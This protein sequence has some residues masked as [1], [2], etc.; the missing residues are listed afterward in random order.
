MQRRMSFRIDMNTCARIIGG[1]FAV[2]TVLFLIHFALGTS[3]VSAQVSDPSAIT[4]SNLTTTSDADGKAETISGTASNYGTT[5]ALTIAAAT[6][7]GSFPQTLSAPIGTGGK[8]TVT[9]SSLFPGER[10]LYSIFDPLGK[11]VSE[12]NFFITADPNSG[13][14][15]PPTTATATATPSDTSVLISGSADPKGATTV[16]VFYQHDGSTGTPG[17]WHATVDLA[18]KFSATITGLDA[19]TKYVYWV[20]TEDGTSLVSQQRFTTKVSTGT[21]TGGGTSG[22]TTGGTSGTTTGGTTTGGTASGPL[23]TPDTT[24]P[25]KAKAFFTPSGTTA[26]VVVMVTGRYFDEG[27]VIKYGTSAKSLTGSEYALFDGL[28]MDHGVNGNAYT[29]TFF[30]LKPLTQYYYEVLGTDGSKLMT[31]PATFSTTV[32]TTN[33]VYRF[34]VVLGMDASEVKA[35]EATISGRVALVTNTIDVRI[36]INGDGTYD[37]V[38]TPPVGSDKTFKFK[39]TD[40]QPDHVYSF[41]ATKVGDPTVLLTYRQSFKTTAVGFAPYVVSVTD[42]TA[43]IASKFTDGVQSPGVIFGT[44]ETD[45]ST[46]PIA[47]T[48]GS[49]GLYTANLSGL[50]A[51]TAYIYKIVGKDKDG[52]V[53]NYSNAYSF[54]T[55]KTGDTIVPTVPQIAD[56][57]PVTPIKYKGFGIVTCKGGLVTDAAKQGKPVG[58]QACGFPELILLIANIIDFLIFL[59]APIIATAVILVAGWLIMTAGGSAENVTKAKGMFMKA[60]IGLVLAMGAWII[61]KFVLVTLGYDD[62]IFAHFY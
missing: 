44:D 57:T 34:N 33:D 32:G 11:T 3:F 29:G 7:G 8:F 55:A 45:I 5:T 25:A 13:K 4:V 60:V 30:G 19:N 15:T 39:V 59:V 22:G 14:A 27:V 43:K 54:L 62:T 53:I 23:G 12:G 18:Y 58:Q 47:L 38:K 51:D 50:K 41:V 17:E 36:D 2:W 20:K 49:D 10:Y 26:S 6:P 61:V 48:K 16:A 1:F 21:G 46:T 56:A 24:S 9:M 28:R 37:S 40:L 31:A 35:T 42:T 52:K